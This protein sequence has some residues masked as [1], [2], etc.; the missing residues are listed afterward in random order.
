VLPATGSVELGG[1]DLAALPRR[2]R[3][4]RVALVEQ[5]ATTELPLTVDDVVA[6]GRTPHQRMLGFGD[7]GD[8]DAAEAV[9]SAI[10]RAGIRHLSGR[11]VTRLSGGERQ[12]VLLA[13][14]LA[15]QPRLLLL[16][17][18]T[19]HL[20]VAAQLA[21]LDLLGEL[22]ADGT[23]VV[24]A[25]HDLGLAAARAQ[26]VVVLAG[27]AAVAEGAPLDV[28]T[29]ELLA[30]VYRVR[31]AWTVNPLTGAPLLALAPLDADG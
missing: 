26:H 6:L 1:A 13:R 7:G 19:N 2:E 25:L 16:D 15:Q 30:E 5:D 31:A 20:D 24:A 23:T 9:A 14:A 11:D 4:R 10:D 8:R 22:A 12:R 3:A 21:P 18:P 28:L 27:G 29:P 17:E